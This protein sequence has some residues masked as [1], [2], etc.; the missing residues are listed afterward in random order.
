MANSAT[1]PGNQQSPVVVKIELECGEC[2][3]YRKLQE[4]AAYP[5]YER[6][7]IPSKAALR[8]AAVA[9]YA[10]KE[11]DEDQFKCVANKT[12]ARGITVAI[13]RA[14]H[15]QHSPTCGSKNTK[16][17]IASDAKTP[18]SLAAARDRD[19]DAMQKH[20]DK[21]NPACAKAYAEAANKVKAHDNEKMIDDAI[22]ECTS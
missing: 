9:R 15:R 3:S 12:E 20:L 22:K 4:K 21:D 14:S 2:G 17:Q 8:E 6:D 10:P 11:F 5:K 1:M 13:P 7:H 16:A 18:E 19:L